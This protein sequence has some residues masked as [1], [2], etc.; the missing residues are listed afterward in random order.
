VTV[1]KDAVLRTDVGFNVYFDGGGAAAPMPVQVAFSVGDRY[2]LRPGGGLRPGMRVV[3]EGNERM[4]PGQP[5]NDIE[6]GPPADARDGSGA[7]DSG[8]GEAGGR[9]AEGGA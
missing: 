3:V 7:P 4:F 9:P 1:H 5:L 8:A 6:A 2:A